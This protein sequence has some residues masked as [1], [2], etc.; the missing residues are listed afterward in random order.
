MRGL[1]ECLTESIFSITKLLEED[2]TND[3]VFSTLVYNLKSINYGK[4]GIIADKYSHINK[5]SMSV[6]LM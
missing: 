2:G 1:E 3:K 6:S 4:L 5:I